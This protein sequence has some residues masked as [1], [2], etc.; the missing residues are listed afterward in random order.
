MQASGEGPHD[1]HRAPRRAAQ[2]LQARG[3]DQPGAHG[4][5]A[6]AWRGLTDTTTTTTTTTNDNNA[7]TTSVITLTSITNTTYDTTDTIISV[8]PKVS[9]W[10]CANE[11]DAQMLNAMELLLLLIL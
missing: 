4:D 11:A 7:T 9:L 10:V 2:R 3:P 5:P 8:G 6:I 1:D